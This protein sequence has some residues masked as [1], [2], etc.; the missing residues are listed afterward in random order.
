MRAVAMV[1][2]LAGCVG[3]EWD[4]VHRLSCEPLFDDIADKTISSD[5]R[6][7]APKYPL[8]SDGAA[9]Q[10][11]LVLPEGGEIDTSDMDHWQVPVGTKLFKEF[12]QGGRRM[13]TRMIER[14][15]EAEYR[16]VPYVWLADESD[17]LAMPEGTTIEGTDYAVPS[18]ELCVTCHGSEP[19]HMLGVSAVQLS[20]QMSELPLTHQPDRH[21]SIPDPAL[22]VL[23][24]NC[25][26]CHNE[27]GV[28]PMQT[29]RFSIADADLPIDQTAPYKTTVGMQL[30]SWKGQ[31]FD[32]RIAPGDLANS[33]IYYRMTQRGDADQMPPIGSAVT[34]ERGIAAVREFII[35]LSPAGR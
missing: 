18:S 23:H 22:G 35:S 1:V 33:A 31:G 17:A 27:R 25:G 19:G 9:K 8:W 28:A 21:Y 6:E 26:H 3:E 16:F 34:D 30:S 5:A 13:E 24:A 20:D 29:L 12:R 11:W 10:R 2:V 32:Y 15:S 4:G 7:L 14:V